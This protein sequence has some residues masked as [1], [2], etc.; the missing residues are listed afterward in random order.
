[1]NKKLYAAL[2][3]LMGFALTVHA[4]TIKL[5]GLTFTTGSD[6]AVVKSY[7]EIP[8]DGK[9]TIPSEIKS[10]R[11]N[12]FS[13]RGPRISART[14]IQGIRIASESFA[15]SAKPLQP[16]NPIVSPESK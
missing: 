13:P 8:E 5:N 7:S 1:M 6:T 4:D 16:S 9:L 10:E 15:I 11:C 2:I 12:P 3:S 14:M